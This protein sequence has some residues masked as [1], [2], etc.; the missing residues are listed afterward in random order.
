MKSHFENDPS[1]PDHLLDINPEVKQA[2]MQNRPVVA[3]ESTIITHGMEYPINR[4][5]ALAVEK[6]V[7][8]YGATPATIAIIKGVIKIG[9]SNEELEMLSTEGKKNSRKCSRR[10]LAYVI[11]RKMNG[12]TT[13]AGTMYLASLAGIKVFVTG[14]IGGVHRGAEQTFDIS[15]DLTEL[16]RTRISVV[17]AGVK[18]ILDIPKTLEYLETMG[19]PVVTYQSDDFPDFFTRKSGLPTVFRCDTPE[20]CA[21][22]IRSQEDLQLN[23]GI[24]FTVP[25]PEDKEAD[26]EKIKAGIDQSLKE[27]EEKGISGALITPFLLKRVNELTGGESSSSSKF[28]IS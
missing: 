6:I 17:S 7:R 22:M 20:E 24:L 28:Q 4:D 11:A 23:T 5:T 10:D 19:V 13:V 12:S 14:G 18:S 1:I 2:L 27:A 25:I 16:A 15:A 8:D 3:L 26:S 21:A 9:L